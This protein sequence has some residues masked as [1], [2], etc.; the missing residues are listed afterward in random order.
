MQLETKNLLKPEK[1]IWKN[2]VPIYSD[3]HFCNYLLFK[4]A[5]LASSLPNT[6]AKYSKL[7]AKYETRIKDLNIE[8]S[9]NRVFENQLRERELEQN[10]KNIWFR[11]VDEQ[12]L[13]PLFYKTKK[14]LAKFQLDKMRQKLMKSKQDEYETGDQGTKEF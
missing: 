6:I 8:F 2:N 1:G 5:T 14:E 9:K 10:F 11:L 13:L 4:R 3:E 7:V 12:E